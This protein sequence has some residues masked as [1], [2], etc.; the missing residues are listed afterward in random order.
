MANKLKKSTIPEVAEK[1]EKSEKPK[2]TVASEQKKNYPDK[3]KKDREEKIDLKKIAKDERT[4]KI[5]GTVSL[6]ISIFLFI[7][8]ISYFFT[9]KEDQDK[10]LNSSVSFL[11]DN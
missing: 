6:L 10:V 3:L 8:F 5:I 7:A 11:F 4:H 1:K 2:K 9:W